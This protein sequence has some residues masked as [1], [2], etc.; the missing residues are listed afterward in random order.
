MV[1][2]VNNLRGDERARNANEMF[3]E[4]PDRKQIKGAMKKM[5]GCSPGEDGIRLPYICK[6]VTK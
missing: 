5:K 4:M 3:Y 1:E 6:V 2:R